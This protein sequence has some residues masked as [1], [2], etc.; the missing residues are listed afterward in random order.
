MDDLV[1]GPG[2]CNPLPTKAT[3]GLSERSILNSGCP[4]A[5][6]T[7]MMMKVAN[8]CFFTLNSQGII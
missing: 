1:K 3:G 6:V 7:M 8:C 5:D 2:G 4:T